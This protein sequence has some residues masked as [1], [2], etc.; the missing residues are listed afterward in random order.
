[1]CVTVQNFVVVGQTVAE[2]WQFFDLFENG[3][4]S[5]VR[6]DHPRTARGGVYH[7]A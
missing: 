3:S 1:M 4:I 6:L 5:C 2:I 7:R